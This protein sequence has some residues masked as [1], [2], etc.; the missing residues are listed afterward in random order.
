MSSSGA[1]SNGNDVSGPKGERAYEICMYSCI[2]SN[3]RTQTH[4]LRVEY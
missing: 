1:I 4:L 3:I 2:H